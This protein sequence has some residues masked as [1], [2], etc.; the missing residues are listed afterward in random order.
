MNNRRFTIISI[1]AAWMIAA[2]GC[3]EDDHRQRAEMAERYLDRQAEQNRR[4][5]ELQH[6]VAE[7]TRQLVEADAKAREEMVALQR[8]LQAEQTEIGRQRDQL[9]SER[10]TLAG[11]RRLDP[12]IAAAITNAALLLACILPLALCWYLL[13]SRD[14]PADDH[15][16][17]EVLLQDLVTDRPLLLP[18]TEPNP[19][20]AFDDDQESQGDPS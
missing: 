20:I 10:R 7:G 1:V 16:V 3:N 4:M 17:A 6:E 14:D 9:E 19:A 8:N 11:Q 13:R 12:I 2:V 5:A 18:K 15:V